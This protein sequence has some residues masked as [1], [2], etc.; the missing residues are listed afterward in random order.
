VGAD[1]PHLR[2]SDFRSVERIDLELGAA[3]D[4]VT[5]D[6]LTEAGTF[7]VY[8]R[9]GDADGALDRVTVNTAR[10][11]EQN[12]VMGF[13]G[14]VIVLGPTFVQIE[15]PERTDQ[16]RMNGRDGDDILSASTDLMAVTLDGGDGVDSLFGGPGRD[17]LIGGRDFDAIDG[18]RGDD[19]AYMG[20]GLGNRF[21]WAPGDG[22]DEIHGGPGPRDSMFFMGSADAERFA[23]EGGRFTRDV[24]NIVMELDDVEIVDALPLGGADAFT[25]GKARDVVELNASLA[26][27]FG[28]PNGDGAAD[29]VEIE[30]TDRDDDVTVTGQKLFSGALTVTGLPVKLGISHA[31]VALDTLV[32]DTLDG[33]DSVD[34]SGLAPDVIGL[35]VN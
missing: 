15:Q 16:V 10:E 1:D 19:V 29:R 26:P 22:S 30:G 33:D 12:F 2:A 20:G 7:E 28:T 24:G 31:E 25:I 34:T 27:S 5:V 23:L 8:V 35:E 3:A 13:D 21:S 9:L 18:R 17:V 6:D 11:G 14:K 4:R 32:I